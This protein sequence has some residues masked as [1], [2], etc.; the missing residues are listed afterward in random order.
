MQNID[1]IFNKVLDG[2]DTDLQFRM[3]ISDYKIIP[4]D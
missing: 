2:I 1:N 3:H 4:V